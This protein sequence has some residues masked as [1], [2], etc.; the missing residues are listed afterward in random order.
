MDDNNICLGCM[1]EKGEEKACPS[2]GWIEGTE[3]ES[4]IYLKP[5]TI[6]AGKY[7]IGKVLGHG[8]FGITYLARDIN[9]GLR[10]AIKEY[11]PQGMASRNLGNTEVSVY[12]GNVKEQFEY[13]LEKFLD[14]AKTIAK[15]EEVPEIVKIRDF[16]KDNGT[17]Y[18]VMNYIEGIT[19]KEYI[20]NNGGR[21]PLDAVLNIMLPVM[22]ALEQV[23]KTGILHRDISPD[24]IYITNSFQV[25]LLDF[26]AARFAIGEHSKSL[27]VVLKPG[28]APEEQYR[29]R[30]NQGPWTDVYA[31]AATMY[32]ALTGETP[33]ESLDRL[34]EDSLVLPSKL[35]VEIPESMEAA[36]AKALKVRAPERYQS[37]SGFMDALLGQ[38]VADKSPETNKPLAV[39]TEKT[40]EIK[41]PDS[42]IKEQVEKAQPINNA[43]G[44]Q[45]VGI[46]TPVSDESTVSRRDNNNKKMIGIILGAAVFICLSVLGIFLM[47]NQTGGHSNNSE[48]KKASGN[49]IM[50]SDIMES[51]NLSGSI[52]VGLAASDYTHKDEF[53]RIAQEFMAEFPNTQV[54]F[55]SYEDSADNLE[56]LLKVK[57]SA[58]DLNDLSII[59]YSLKNEQLSQQLVP[60]D[61]LGYTKD[62]LYTYDSGSFDG[63]LYKIA[64]IANFTGVLYNKTAFSSAGINDIPLTVD[65]FMDVCRKLKA[66]GITPVSTGYA[67]SWPLFTWESIYPYDCSGNPGIKMEQIKTG[68]YFSGSMV[69]G[70][71]LLRSL[72]E[73]G[74]LE[75]N[76]TGD[77][78]NIMADKLKAGTD[79]MVYMGDWFHPDS[80][81]IGMFPAPGAKAID[82]SSGYGFGVAKYSKSPFVAKAFLK[83]L[84]ED[85][86]Y[87]KA[88]GS[89][90][91]SVKGSDLQ[92]DYIKQLLGF[93]LPTVD[94][95]ADYRE[96]VDILKTCGIN[97]EGSVAKNYIDS[98][99][100]AAYIDSINSKIANVGIN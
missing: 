51:K 44:Q 1:Q 6:L 27:S 88:I 62:N 16:F 66:A 97:E 3:Q 59:P 96:A 78:F 80:P 65:D 25:R 13:G 77:S 60:L 52:V 72:K 57:V 42:N 9:L 69:K 58:G 81:D 82:V 90:N 91:P 7:L 84:L 41:K 99:D 71:E 10:L 19:L 53:D 46:K 23:H 47:V 73:E 33:P 11:L 14:E 2:C 18:I 68:S 22:K 20:A 83:Y 56:T 32:K 92:P 5:G 61:D 98:D 89:K 50:V 36:I 48:G 79:A 85:D 95:S 35:G 87:C 39:D 24:N 100:P 93:G 94:G 8:G 70:L 43:G 12:S 26:G 30:G 17:A 29:S 37:M 34:E 15:F 21:L 74:Y 28:Y 38:Q 49:K 4:P 31:T 45:N 64:P 75:D 54:S 86:R 40:V 76:L 67:D 63:T 55:E